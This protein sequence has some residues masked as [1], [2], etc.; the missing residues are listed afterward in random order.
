MSESIASIM[1]AEGMLTKLKAPFS[2]E[3]FEAFY[4]VCMYFARQMTIPLEL[5]VLFKE[6][7]HPCNRV[8]TINRNLFSS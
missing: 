7:L 3:S 1:L 2:P 5:Q 6:Q 4:C 8:L